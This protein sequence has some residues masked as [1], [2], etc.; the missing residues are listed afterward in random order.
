MAVDPRDP[1]LLLLSAVGTLSPVVG[2]LF[3]LV[4]GGFRDR[5]REKDAHIADLRRQV[6]GETALRSVVEEM[7]SM[8]KRHEWTLDE[9]SELVQLVRE[10]GRRGALD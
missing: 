1:L 6:D 10:R 7:R 9:V 2:V 5:L 4:I 8:G 3:W